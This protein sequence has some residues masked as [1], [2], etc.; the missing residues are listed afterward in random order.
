[1]SWFGFL[2]VS[3]LFHSV[4]LSLSASGFVRRP[5]VK[6]VHGTELLAGPWLCDPSAVRDLREVAASGRSQQWSVPQWVL[7]VLCAQCALVFSVAVSPYAPAMGVGAVDLVFSA[8]G[9][10]LSAAGLMVSAIKS[11]PLGYMWFDD[12]VSVAS[13]YGLPS[14]YFGCWFSV[15]LLR[16]VV[17]YWEWRLTQHTTNCPDHLLVLVLAISVQV[18]LDVVSYRFRLSILTL[19]L[20]FRF[21]CVLLRRGTTRCSCIT[22]LAMAITDLFEDSSSNR[23]D[24]VY[25]A[26]YSCR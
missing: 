5:R 8:M 15:T 23:H 13:G 7:S 25:L 6:G 1:M 22:R 18:C 10:V 16:E 19:V 20:S 9:L 21:M 24:G 14:W 4:S 3:L 2:D 11:V 12:W 17:A 26:Y